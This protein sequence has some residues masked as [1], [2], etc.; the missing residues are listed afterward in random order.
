MTACSFY[1]KGL[2]G[3]KRRNFMLDNDF[4][5]TYSLFVKKDR[6]QSASSIIC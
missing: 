6:L 5:L 4:S 1:W 3:H 2:R